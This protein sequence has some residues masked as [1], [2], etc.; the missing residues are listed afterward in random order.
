M[1]ISNPADPEL[2]FTINSLLGAFS[3]AV[4]GNY[5][6]LSN[7]DDL[8]VLDVSNPAVPLQ[9]GSY[10]SPAF[11][12][13]V[14]VS[15]NIAYLAESWGVRTVDITNPHDPTSIGQY[16]TPYPVKSVSLI[17]NVM[18]VS[19]GE[20]GMRI[21]DATDPMNLVETGYYVEDFTTNDVAAAGDFVY[22]A[23]DAAFSIY[24]VSE[25]I[26]LINGVS[27]D[28]PASVATE[29]RLNPVFPNPFNN[30][31]NIMFD[32]P[33]EVTGKL[34]VYDVLGRVANTL[35]DG[36]LSAGSHQMQFNGY[37]LSSGTYFVKLETPD[38]HAVRKAVLLK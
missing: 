28:D 3:L 31:A 26:A 13:D 14:A 6:Y 36:K 20:Y 17:G 19:E 27:V 4:S 16:A 5:A 10:D 18:Y 33:H 35:F 8:R 30:T 34:V 7:F 37:G 11:V 29:F 1:D 2:V 22:S 12:Y 21:V 32:L 24:D 25:A 38:F 9:V 23:E 15:G